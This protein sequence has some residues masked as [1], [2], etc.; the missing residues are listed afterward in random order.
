[1][2]ELPAVQVVWVDLGMANPAGTPTEHNAS[3]TQRWLHHG[4]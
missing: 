1:M 4:V 3:D 2:T